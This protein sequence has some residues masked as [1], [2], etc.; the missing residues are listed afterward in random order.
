[1]YVFGA[2]YTCWLHAMPLM[3]KKYRMPLVYYPDYQTLTFTPFFVDKINVKIS[4]S[5][6]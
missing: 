2:N 1:M 6:V 3:E 5:I 4:T